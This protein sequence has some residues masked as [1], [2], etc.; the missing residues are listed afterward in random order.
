MNMMK[1]GW[2]QFKHYRPL[3]EQLVIKDI[4]LKYRRSFLGYVWSILNPLMIMIIMVIVFSQ[5][6][7][8][9]I[10]NYPVYFIIGSTLFNF[11]TDS[12]TQAM[13]SITGNA[14][15]LKKT[16]VPKYIFTLS[17]ITSSLVNTLFSLGA[18]LIVFVVCDVHFNIYMLWIIAVLLQVYLFSMGLGLFLA[19]GTVFFRDIQYIYSA[20]TTA[21][22][23]LTPIFYPIASLPESIQMVI[24]TFNPMYGYIEQFRL[25]VLNNTFPDVKMIVSGFVI[26]FLSLLIG[27]W[28]FLKAQDKFILYI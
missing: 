18:M 19:Q 8:F 2:E 22:T 13:W 1:S 16:Y 23:Y 6:F 7:R 24:K 17:K 3:M 25:I 12:T 10:E 9:D 11:M 26:A 4:K 15:L 20:V 21:W 28:A 14:A 5:M 27:S